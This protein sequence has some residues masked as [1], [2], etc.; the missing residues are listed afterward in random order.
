MSSR[1]EIIPYRVIIGYARRLD[2][3]HSVWF[4]LGGHFMHECLH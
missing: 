2:A 4:N 3:R 1:E